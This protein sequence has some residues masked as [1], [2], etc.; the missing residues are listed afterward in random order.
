[1]SYNVVQQLFVSPKSKKKK[2]TTHD[3]TNNGGK[4]PVTVQPLKTKE[5][6]KLIAD[7]VV[8]P[9]DEDME[10]LRNFFDELEKDMTIAVRKTRITSR[11][12]EVPLKIVP[13]L[14]II[15]ILSLDELSELLVIRKLGAV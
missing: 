6:N 4:D 3:D 12:S 8:D 7:I 9:T 14:W 15:T 1:M 5:I 11:Q 10:T 2:D 13:L